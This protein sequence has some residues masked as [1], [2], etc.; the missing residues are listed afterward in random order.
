MMSMKDI[1]VI[2]ASQVLAGPFAAMMLGD[3]GCDVIKVEPLEG[4]A[5]RRS[6]GTNAPWGETP[7]F[8]NL[9][10]N[11]RSIALDLK[12]ERGQA[13]FH[14]LAAQCDVVIQNFRPGVA[15]RLGIAYDYLRPLNDRLIFCSIS[16][17]GNSESHARRGGYDIM[18]QAMSG[19]MSVTG[20]AGGPPGRSGVPVAD[21]G[22][23][24]FAAFGILGALITREQTGLGCRVET[25]LLDSALAYAVWEST[26]YWSSGLVPR[27]L[28]SAHPM[29]A[30]YQAFRCK[31]GYITIGANNDRLWQRLCEALER[32]D[33]RT[34]A[35]FDTPEH[36]VLH[37]EVLA[38][39]IEAS[40][41]DMTRSE[42]EELLGEFRVPAGAVRT[43]DEVL[44]SEEAVDGGMVQQAEYSGYPVRFL[45]SPLQ[46]D[47]ARIGSARRP[48]TLGEH[49]V[50]I[51]SWLGCSTADVS[52]LQSQGVVNK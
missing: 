5:T 47:G 23:G 50:E 2:D 41:A 35:R 4:D 10:R 14:R 11:K 38:Q 20:E 17:F 42:V 15:E 16:A 18:A 8:L 29:N 24:L 9:N 25:N 22:A 45:G 37:K 44:D 27:A 13:I 21:I 52:E 33:W 7:G 3:L 48:P 49:T 39:L 36:R 12:S 6:F 51:L 28:G 34:D 26:Q 31:D 1:R 43:Y 30:P 40:I 46:V 19:I 32:P